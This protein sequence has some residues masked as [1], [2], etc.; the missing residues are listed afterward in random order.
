[1]NSTYSFDLTGRVALVTGASSGIGARFA[2]NLAGAG[3]K[4]VLAARRKDR[5]DALVAE[6]AAR[7][8][9]AFA[10][11]MDVTDEVSTKTAFDVA[12]HRFGTVDTIIAN[13]GASGAGAAL[14]L[15]VI[16]FDQVTALNSRGVGT[17]S[18]CG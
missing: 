6:I 16:E 3:A 9:E 15:P 11:T 18:A 17:P 10:V 5:L 1:M 12:E 7:G 8:G 4:V 14:D 13:A 2:Q